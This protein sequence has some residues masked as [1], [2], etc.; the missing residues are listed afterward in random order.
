LTSETPL[1][2]NFPAE[3]KIRLY[4]NSRLTLFDSCHRKFYLSHELG[5]SLQ[6][7]E[8]APGFGNCWHTSMDVVWRFLC[9]KEGED[10]M[11]YASTS[12]AF[13][14]EKAV[15]AF[16]E[17]WM[18]QG[19]P[20]PQNI[21]A[22]DSLTPRTPAVGR[23][24]LWN[25]IEINWDFIAQCEL[26]GV[27]Q[28]FLVLLD[29]DDPLL[30]Y[31]GRMDKI[32]YNRSTGF[33]EV[34]DHKSTKAYAKHGFFRDYFSE[35]FSPNSQVDGYSYA[36]HMCYGDKYNGDVRIDA[37]L[38]HKTVHNGFKFFV[39]KRPAGQ[40]DAWRWETLDRIR[41][42]E[43]NRDNLEMEIDNAREGFPSGYTPAFRKDNGA[44]FDYM[45]ACVFMDTCKYTS[46]PHQEDPPPGFSVKRWSPFKQID[47]QQLGITPERTTEKLND[48]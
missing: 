40:L 21:A 29:P 14:H 4:D 2:P 37:A 16:M 30:Y 28:P 20:D 9:A 11:R 47:L 25:Y 46:S 33:I 23:E 41:S 19:L 31:C 3:G 36:A 22:I 44:C 1:N 10:P 6:G 34:V 43:A 5:W 17:E 13:V 42:I 12:H 38:V 32:I 8:I 26:I 24:M 45:K 39:S 48:E 18:E 7:T 15:E 27:E 35:S